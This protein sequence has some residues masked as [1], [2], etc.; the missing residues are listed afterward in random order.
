ML[1]SVFIEHVKGYEAI[2]SQAQAAS[3]SC[4]DYMQ[5]VAVKWPVVY[6]LPCWSVRS[7]IWVSR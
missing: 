1:Y 3:Y 5:T 4:V 7:I 6:T 2:Y